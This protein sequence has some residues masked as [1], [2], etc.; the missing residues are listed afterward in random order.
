MGTGGPV[1]HL[2]DARHLRE[3]SRHAQ[4]KDPNHDLFWF[5]LVTIL[6]AIIMVMGTKL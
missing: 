3:M 4:D 2:H 5:V 6:L 1:L